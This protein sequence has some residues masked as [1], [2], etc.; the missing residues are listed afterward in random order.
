MSTFIEVPANKKSLNQR[1]PVYGVG[2]NDAPYKTNPLINNKRTICPY[3]AKWMDMIVRCYSENFQTTSPTYKGCS[4]AKEWLT[5]S[6]FKSWMIKQ[7]WQGKELDKDIIKYGNKIYSPSNCRFVTRELNV[8]L[9]I[10][11]ASKRKY[12]Q[13]VCRANNGE[14][15]FSRVMNNGNTVHIG[16]YETQKEASEAYKAA[17]TKIILEAAANQ[18]DPAIAAGLKEYIKRELSS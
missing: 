9:Y 13:G 16:V 8:L 15:Y 18:K 2:I 17:K 14:K 1:K 3:Y 6:N 5:F 7:D 11:P 4:V 10:H 12:P